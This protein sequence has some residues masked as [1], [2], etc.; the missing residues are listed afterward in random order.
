MDIKTIL[1]LPIIVALLLPHGSAQSKIA[2]LPSVEQGEFLGQYLYSNG[3]TGAWF[4]LSADGSYEYKTFS[5]CCD[6]VWHETGA[7][8]LKDKVLHFRII[9]KTLDKYDLLDHEQALKA[10]RTLYDHKDSDLP[11]EVPRTEYDM[12]I[13]RWGERIYLIDPDKLNLFAAA[14]NFGVEPRQDI[15][16]QNYLAIDFFLRGGDEQKPVSGKPELSQPWISYLHDTAIKT[17]VTGIETENQRRVYTVNK[18]IAD[19]VK[20]SMCFVGENKVLKYNNLLFVISVEERSAKLKSE[21]FFR[22]PDYQA[23]SILITKSLKRSR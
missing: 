20:V 6:P 10:F 7:Y 8:M 23:G 13:V 16:N 18:G 4:N 11:S 9:K 12:Q 19:G 15:I 1:Y 21:A 14:V 3:Y 17:K 5:D 2:A 22:E